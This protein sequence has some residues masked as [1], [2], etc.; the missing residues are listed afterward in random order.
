MGVDINCAS[1]GGRCVCL[2]AVNAG[3]RAGF[4]GRANGKRAAITAECHGITELIPYVGSASVRGLDGGLLC[5]RRSGADEYVN[6]AGS[7]HRPIL[8]VTV[9]TLGRTRFPRGRDD[10]Q[11]A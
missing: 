9:D 3:G 1:F 2:S 7:L 4:A 6:G 8:L 10:E 11:V 5:P